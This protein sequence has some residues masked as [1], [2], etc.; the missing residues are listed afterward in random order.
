[1]PTDKEFARLADYEA[2]ITAI[3]NAIAEDELDSEYVK[4]LKR[5]YRSLKDDLQAEV[6]AHTSLGD[7]AKEAIGNLATKINTH[8]IKAN[9][10]SG[11]WAAQTDIR[12]ELDRL[13]RRRRRT[14]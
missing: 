8:P 5:D 1:M 14:S 4:Q 11:L 13:R 9:W 10:A 12:H 3:I 2:R 6:K 7:V